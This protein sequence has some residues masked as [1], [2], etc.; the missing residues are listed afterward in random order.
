MVTNAGAV[1]EARPSWALRFLKADDPGRIAAAVKQ[2]EVSTAAEVVPM[3][4]GRS[5]L[6]PHVFP[7][8]AGW[9][10]ALFY[11][12]LATES[13]L[14]DEPLALSPWILGGVSLALVGLAA[15]ASRFDLVRRWFTADVHLDH[16]VWHRAVTEFYEAGWHKTEG[17]TGILLLVSLAEHRAVVLA[18]K[19]IAAKLPPDAWAGVVKTLIQGVKQGDLGEGFAAAIAECGALVRPHFPIDERDRNE[20]RD[21]LVIKE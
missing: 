14:R 12:Y 3:L 4:V 20:L 2:V 10:L 1:S 13:W 8:L 21:A 18:D 5:A 19:T 9:A 16:A 15:L 7:L 17:Q 11:F 6:V